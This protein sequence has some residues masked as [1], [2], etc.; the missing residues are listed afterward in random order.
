VGNGVS[1]SLNWGNRPLP[2]NTVGQRSWHRKLLAFCQVPQAEPL[3]LVPAALLSTQLSSRFERLLGTCASWLT[4]D[5]TP[6]TT[7]CNPESQVASENVLSSVFMSVLCTASCLQHC[8]LKIPNLGTECP[9][10]FFP[11]WQDKVLS[12]RALLSWTGRPF[13][14]HLCSA[15]RLDP[16]TN[17]GQ[18]CKPKLSAGVGTI[19]RVT[20]GLFCFL[21][22]EERERKPFVRSGGGRLLP[23]PKETWCIHKHS[24]QEQIKLR[25]VW[26]TLKCAVKRSNDLSLGVH[27][28]RV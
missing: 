4:P 24:L 2:P 13:Y 9:S 1:H 20:M 27:F 18:T 7:N 3:S 21:K 16:Q 23:S 5:L 25:R 14:L 6:I 19:G 10:P 12:P 17:L 28:V 15:G 22:A 11:P 8:D 26:G